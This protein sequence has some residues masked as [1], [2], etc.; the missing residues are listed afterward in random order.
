[1]VLTWV[2]ISYVRSCA[3]HTFCDRELRPTERLEPPLLL[4]WAWSSA[5]GMTAVWAPEAEV[6]GE[7]IERGEDWEKEWM[8]AM[9]DVQA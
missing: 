5:A 4:C 9:D 2:T 1:M 3:L 7:W 6:S 8:L